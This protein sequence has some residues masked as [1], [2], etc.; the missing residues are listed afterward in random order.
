LQEFGIGEPLLS[1]KDFADQS[2][3]K[4]IIR[5]GK[6]HVGVLIG[7]LA[8]TVGHAI[9]IGDVRY[10]IWFELEPRKNRKVKQDMPDYIL[11]QSSFIDGDGTLV[12]VG[13]GHKDVTAVVGRTEMTDRDCE[14]LLKNESIF[15]Q[16]LKRF[17]SATE[18]AP[19]GGTERK[20]K[21]IEVVAWRKFSANGSWDTAHSRRYKGTGTN[22]AKDPKYE[23]DLG[24]T[25]SN[26][27]LDG[28]NRP[29]STEG[30][31]SVGR[32]YGPG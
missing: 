29:W 14:F 12:E 11:D 27:K 13:P 19:P 6:T 21:T 8:A 7:D 17:L 16:R 32:F 5:E 10:G 18:L 31:I 2:K 26:Y 20:I 23:L 22:K 4:E 15:M 1:Y 30:P 28:I 25:K 24:S 9:M 3:R